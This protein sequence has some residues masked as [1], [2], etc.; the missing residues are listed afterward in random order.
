MIPANFSGI[1]LALQSADQWVIWRKENV[2]EEKPRGTKVPYIPWNPNYHASSTKPKSWGTFD[3]AIAGVKYGKNV[4][5]VGF[6]LTKGVG[7]TCI[8]IDHCVDG[9]TLSPFAQEVL[10]IFDNKTYIEASYNR[11]GLHIF[12]K[13][14][15]PRC[16]GEHGGLEIYDTGR[17]IAITGYKLKTCNPEIS[18]C[19]NELD[20]IIQTYWKDVRVSQPV[21]RSKPQQNC[22]GGTIADR[23]GLTCSSIGYPGNAVFIGNKIR[24]S[25]PVHGSTTGMN[26][27]IDDSQNVWHCFRHNCGG[28][29]IE[30]YAMQQGIIDCGE[31]LDGKWKE[32]FEALR[33]DGYD[34]QKAGLEAPVF[35]GRREV[36]AFLGSI[37]VR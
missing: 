28:G 4:D 21:A 2:T 22:N 20:E 3:A 24:G 26:F 1:P 34:L 8:D 5:G 15:L 37:G 30:L 25:H 23:L 10:A 35:K 36:K 31:R 32:I 19:Q 27:T 16:G 6:V 13:G 11:D 14:N 29:A 18:A 33:N 9:D 17:Y 7:I 12:L